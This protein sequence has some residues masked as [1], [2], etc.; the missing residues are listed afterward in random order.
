VSSYLAEEVASASGID[1]GKIVLQP[2]PLDVAHYTR[3]S[4]GGAGVV[5]V[6]RLVQQKNIAT[7]LEAVAILKQR[8]KA[9]TLKVIGD[10]PDRRSLEHRAKQLG[11]ADV[12][13]FVG[14]VPPE[15]VPEQIGDADVFAFPAVDEGLGLA[16]AEAFMLGVPV[17]AAQQGGGV[18]DFVPSSG[19]GRLVDATDARQMAQE[20][21]MMVGNAESRRL[22]SEKGD[23]LKRQLN[24][25]AVAELFESVYTQAMAHE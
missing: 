4:R 13:R 22:A 17:I 14:T 21:E 24:P 2:M 20:I 19:A 6:G 15:E 16:A 8:D 12:T 23:A 3:Q 9:V 5:T 18:R 1:P 25:D 10:G 7:I 11:I